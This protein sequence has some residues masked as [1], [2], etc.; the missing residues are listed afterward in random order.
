MKSFI[1]KLSSGA[2]EKLLCKISWFKLI[3]ALFPATKEKYLFSIEAR[4]A[5]RLEENLKAGIISEELKKIFKTQGF[6]LSENATI[7]KETDDKWVI[8][9]NKEPYDIKKECGKLKV[10]EPNYGFVET[11]ILW[12]L[13]FSL[14]CLYFSPVPQIQRLPWIL[15]LI[16]LLQNN[17]PQNTPVLHDPSIQQHFK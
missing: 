4:D 3:Q 16:D 2:F 1:V 6:P 13:G 14:V 11:W 9:S 15:F 8:A 7:S 12:N 5:A 17:T 10:C